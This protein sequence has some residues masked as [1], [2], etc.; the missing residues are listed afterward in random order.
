M[1]QR[2]SSRSRR[3][4]QRKHEHPFLGP[5]GV[6]AL[7]RKC[8]RYREKDATHLGG[9]D[10]WLYASSNGRFPLAQATVAVEKAIEAEGN[11]NPGQAEADRAEA[12]R[13]AIDALRDGDPAAVLVLGALAEGFDSPHPMLGDENWSWALAACRRGLDCSAQASWVQFGAGTKGV[14]SR[15][16]R[17]RISCGERQARDSKRGKGAR[18][19]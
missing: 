7:Q 14:V 1:S 12:I 17:E 9:R 18:R 13:L 6:A 19:K 15:T 8:R 3:R 4:W 2:P 5:D 16:R 11:R 10:E